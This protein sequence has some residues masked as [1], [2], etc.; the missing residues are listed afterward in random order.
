MTP[1]LLSVSIKHRL[2]GLELNASFQAPSGR[3]ALFGPS[4]AGKTTI[5]KTIAGLLRPDI[6]SISLG[7]QV[8]ED[9]GRNTRLHPHERRAAIVFQDDR[10]FPHLSVRKNL[11]YGKPKGQSL[12]LS[13]LISLTGIEA[14]LDRSVHTLSGGE[15]KR[16]AIARALASAPQ[17]LLLDE[18]Y[19][20]LDRATALRLRADLR[21]LLKETGTPHVLVSHHLDD[22]LAHADDVALIEAGCVVGFGTPEE[23]FTS[24]VGMRLIGIADETAPAGP[25]TILRVARVK[26]SSFPGIQVWELANGRHLLLG[27]TAETKGPTWLKIRGVDVSLSLEEPGATSVL[28]VLPAQVTELAT[29]GGYV[30]A[31]LDLGS[32]VF[33]TARITSYSASKLK[34]ASGMQVHAMIKAA[35]LTN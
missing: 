1:A 18:P 16:V 34:L 32:G 8:W 11:L 13:E 19:S 21:A 29:R 12:R 30:D 14:L 28:N 23:A 35:A 22:V 20:G 5:L 31:A 9:S 6:A 10:L 25:L 2:P 15:R 4:G 33:L 17:L 24:P 3:L 27:G 7:E 26:S